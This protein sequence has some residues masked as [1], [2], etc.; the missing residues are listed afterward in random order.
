MLLRPADYGASQVSGS[1][2]LCSI[3]IVCVLLPAAAATATRG[4][5]I[6][7]KRSGH[8]RQHERQR[9][10]RKSMKE[11]SR[12]KREREEVSK[13]PNAEYTEYIG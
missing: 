4:R 5:S 10:E 3:P 7:A 13:I 2:F 12:T 6:D 8:Q 9:A 1:L 11:R